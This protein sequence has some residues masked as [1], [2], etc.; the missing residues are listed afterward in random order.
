MFR[1]R[2]RLFRMYEAK[3]NEMQTY[4]NNLGFLNVS[5][6]S[7]N[8]FVNEIRRKIE[9]LKNEVANLRKS[10]EDID[11]KAKAGTQDES[12]TADGNAENKE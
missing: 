8:G 10:I 3:R 1:E 9:N 2:E 4:E 5:S 6:K 11:E 7:G 12:A